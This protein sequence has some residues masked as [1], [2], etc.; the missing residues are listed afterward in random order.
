MT[1]Q[2]ARGPEKKIQKISLEAIEVLE[3]RGLAG[4]AVEAAITR[5][6]LRQGEGFYLFFS[7]KQELIIDFLRQTAKAFHP[8]EKKKHPPGIYCLK[9]YCSVCLFLFFIPRKAIDIE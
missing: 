2:R 7:N 3:K 1:G 5:T 4:L 6:S 8:V 9:R